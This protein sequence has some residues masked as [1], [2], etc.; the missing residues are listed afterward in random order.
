MTFKDKIICLFNPI[1]IALKYKDDI[2]FHYIERLYKLD[3]IEV[4][5]NNKH[6]LT[7]NLIDGMESYKYEKLGILHNIYL[8][9]MNNK[10]NNAK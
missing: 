3:L 2:Y 8:E 5:I 6:I 4:W 7:Y 1:K 10:T 9:R